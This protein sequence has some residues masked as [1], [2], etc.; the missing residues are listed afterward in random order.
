MKKTFLVKKNPGLPG[1]E[2]NWTIM[3]GFDFAAF[4]KTEEGKSRSRSFGK[5]RGTGFDDEMIVIECGE[6]AAV[7]LKAENDHHKMLVEN[8]R[9]SGVRTI[10]FDDICTDPENDADALETIADPDKDT[11]ADAIGNLLKNK[12]YE[13]YWL[14]P[15]REREMI[16]RMYLSNDPESMRAYSK[17]KGLSVSTVQ[18]RHKKALQFMKDYIKNGIIREF[19]E[20][21]RT[22][23]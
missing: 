23:A 2:D 17:S 5:L 18:Y 13:G 3:N 16:F 19:F 20:K 15:E 12:L 6:A 1:S 4:M 9:E 8:E 7:K 22:D 11:E 10:G 14:L 21:I